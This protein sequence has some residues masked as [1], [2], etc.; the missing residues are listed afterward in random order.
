LLE[1]RH[2]AGTRLPLVEK[3]SEGLGRKRAAEKI[4]L[5]LIAP[6]VLEELQ[7]LFGLQSN[8]GEFQAR[9]SSRI[10]QWGIDWRMDSTKSPFAADVARGSGNSGSPGG[11]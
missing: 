3:C 11:N 10:A 1:L 9:L 8:I 4:A 2:P 5:D 6:A 7:L